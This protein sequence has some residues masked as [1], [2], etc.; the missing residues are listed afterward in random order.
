MCTP[1]SFIHDWRDFPV[2]VYKRTPHD[3]TRVH[4]RTHCGICREAFQAGEK[5][6]DGS[7]PKRTVHPACADQHPL[8]RPKPPVQVLSLEQSQREIWL[9]IA[10]HTEA[11][12]LQ[13]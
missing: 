3:A 2:R 1:G 12:L 4:L 6:I 10:P 7:T 9:Q 11:L 13:K 8:C 5:Y